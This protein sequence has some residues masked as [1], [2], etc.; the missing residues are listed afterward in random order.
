MWVCDLCEIYNGVSRE[1]VEEN[2]TFILLLN[3]L[4]P[5]A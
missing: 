4:F 1:M 2:E 5:R 3:S